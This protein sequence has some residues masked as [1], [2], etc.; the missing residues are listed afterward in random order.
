MSVNQYSKIGDDAVLGTDHNDV[1]GSIS[2]SM[3][4]ELHVV[5][6]DV[7]IISVDTS[8]S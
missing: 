4:F 8:V 2:M 5:A 1:G 7:D 6:V 3:I